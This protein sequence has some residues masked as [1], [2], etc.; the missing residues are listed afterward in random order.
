MEAVLQLTEAAAFQVKDMMKQ[1]EESDSY[2]R[3]AVN[4]GGCSGLS[5]GMTL[6]QTVQEDDIVFEQHGI[7]VVVDKTSAPILKGT[8]IDYKQSL[9]GGGFTIDNPNAIATCGCG[10]SFRTANVAGTPGEC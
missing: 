4:G 10:S 8:K 2:L 1:A 7:K 6:D 9:L 5:Y 3:V